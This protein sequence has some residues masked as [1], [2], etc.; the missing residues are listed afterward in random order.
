MISTSTTH[1]KPTLP[2]VTSGPP[3]PTTPGA[4]TCQGSS[5]QPTRAVPAS[6]LVPT[7]RVSTTRSR[8]EATRRNSTRWRSVWGTMSGPAIDVQRSYAVTA[9]PGSLTPG[10]PSRSLPLP[11]GG[12]GDGGPGDG[13]PGDG[14]PGDG[15]PGAGAC[16]AQDGLGAG[17]CPAQHGLPCV[18]VD[19][20]PRVHCRHC[21][22]QRR[23][24]ADTMYHRQG[25]APGTGAAAHPARHRG[26][27]PAAQPT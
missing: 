20:P 6:A 13:G 25:A 17:A 3:S 22:Q 19:G 9:D 21:G 18:L 4:G 16:P 7:R 15:G 10:R 1:R 2:A 5:N 27:V 24:L 23:R 26:L 12:P 14:G 8:R 11:D